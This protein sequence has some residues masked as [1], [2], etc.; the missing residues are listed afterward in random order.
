VILGKDLQNIMELPKIMFYVGS[1]GNIFQA[2]F[3]TSSLEVHNAVFVPL[4]E[5]PRSSSLGV[6][7]KNANEIVGQPF[8]FVL[9][10]FP[11]C[12]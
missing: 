3:A 5:V 9:K 1:P 10:T 11:M 6:L 8:I 2:I 7:I 4:Q 12:L